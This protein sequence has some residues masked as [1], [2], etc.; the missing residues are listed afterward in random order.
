MIGSAGVAAWIA[1]VAFWVLLLIGFGSGELR[2]IGV[3][4]FV[5]LWLI[6]RFGLPLLPSGA[7]LLTPYLAVVDIA[8]VF[9]V[10]KGDVRLS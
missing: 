10:F 7:V 8:L 4:V 6:G 1:Q 9:A 2:R 5:G 3:A